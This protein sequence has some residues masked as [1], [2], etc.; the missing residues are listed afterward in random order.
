MRKIKLKKTSI[1]Y[2]NLAIF[3]LSV[4][5]AVVISRLEIFHMFLL[6]LGELGYIGAFIAGILFVSTFTV[7]TGAV[8][9][10]VLAEKLPFYILAII[11]GVGAVVGDLTIFHFIKYSI[12]DEL[13]FF[14]YKL[15]GAYCNR[16]LHTKYFMWTLPVLGAFIIA[17]PLPDE[18]GISLMG[19]SKMGTYKFIVLSFLLNTIGIMLLLST[20]SFIQP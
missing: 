9:L 13:K 3:A 7:A 15:G 19:I 1:N 17:S 6:S 20:S 16:V 10:F 4:I 18:I 2:R 12:I 11:A 14:Y 8:I 5:V